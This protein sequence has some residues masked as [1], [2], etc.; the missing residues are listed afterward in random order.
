VTPIERSET[1]S[2]TATASTVITEAVTA[3]PGV[4]AGPGARGASVAFRVAGREIGHLHGDHSL[5]TSFPPELWE[6]L[7]A[8]GRIEPHPVFPDKRGP[9]ARRIASEEDVRDAIALLRIRYDS[10][11]AREER[12]ASRDAQ[13]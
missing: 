4:Q 12:L 2:E 1:M 9:A 6:R 3:W 10:A 7:R 11:L 5:H 8:E 13:A